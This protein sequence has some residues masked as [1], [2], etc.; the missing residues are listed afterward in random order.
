[1]AENFADA[2]YLLSVKLYDDG[3]PFSEMAHL[4]G[5]LRFYAYSRSAKKWSG[6]NPTSP[7]AGYNHGL[8]EAAVEL[9]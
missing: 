1:M 6:Q 2:S 4:T 8:L 9:L 3:L 7:T 5:S